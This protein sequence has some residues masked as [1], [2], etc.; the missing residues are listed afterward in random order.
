M[1]GP[2]MG[3]PRRAP[4]AGADASWLGWL[5][6][7][8]YRPTGGLGWL[9]L[10]WDGWLGLGFAWLFGFQ[11]FRLDFGFGL[12][13]GWIFVIRLDFGWVRLDFGFDFAFAFAFSMIFA[14]SSFS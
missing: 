10:A 12:I 2:L 6:G 1:Q 11:R 3:S 5:P 9:R 4:Q 7:H 13:F 8:L 14:H